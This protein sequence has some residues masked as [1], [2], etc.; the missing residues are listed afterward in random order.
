MLD[1]THQTGC[2]DF[3]ARNSL[4]ANQEVVLLLADSQLEERH[5]LSGKEGE[6]SFPRRLCLS[7]LFL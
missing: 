2:C 3:T 7:P 6:G 1:Y 4:R 5:V